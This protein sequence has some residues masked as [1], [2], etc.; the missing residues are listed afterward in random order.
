MI[1]IILVLLTFCT[2]MFP[3]V[4]NHKVVNKGGNNQDMKVSIRNYLLYQSTHS[5]K[6]KDNDSVDTS[7]IQ[8]L[9]KWYS[10]ITNLPDDMVRFYNKEITIN[11]IPL[12]LGISAATAGLIL[13]DNST[14]KASHKFYNTNSF[15]KRWSDIIV[16]IGDGSS[17]FGLAGGL[18]CMV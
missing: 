12:F 6:L 4:K 2:F 1:K 14:W 5:V 18:C 16:K 8:Y 11:N 13:T 17:Q 9:P 7:R 10:M 15:N 3:G